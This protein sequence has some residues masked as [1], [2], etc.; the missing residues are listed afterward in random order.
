MDNLKVLIEEAVKKITALQVE[1]KAKEGRGDGY[2][3]R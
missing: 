1:I 2:P 3:S